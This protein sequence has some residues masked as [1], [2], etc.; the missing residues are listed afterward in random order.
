MSKKPGAEIPANALDRALQ[1][2]DPASQQVARHAR[3]IG[4]EL[5]WDRYQAQQ[6]Q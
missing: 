5:V 1:T 6:P 3:E 4:L 2:M